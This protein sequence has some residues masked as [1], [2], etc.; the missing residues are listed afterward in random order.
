MVKCGKF[1]WSHICKSQ[2]TNKSVFFSVPE[3]IN[4]FEIH[5]WVVVFLREIAVE[6]VNSGEVRNTNKQTNN[7][8]YLLKSQPNVYLMGNNMTI[9]TNGEPRNDRWYTQTLIII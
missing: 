8:D 6:H 4:S 2:N 1:T 7:P 9:S 5:D 3:F